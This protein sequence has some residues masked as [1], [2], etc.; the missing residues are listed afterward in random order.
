M[1]PLIIAA[2][3]G[4]VG[5]LAVSKIL[6]KDKNFYTTKE[7]AELLKI[8]EYTVRKKIREGEIQAE[9]GKSYR[10]S[11][12]ALEEYLENNLPTELLDL[13]NAESLNPEILQQII[14]LKE[15]DLKRLKL[16]LQKLELEVDDYDPKEFQKR[17]LALEIDINELEAEIKRQRLISTINASIAQKKSEN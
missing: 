1:I 17:K 5:T 16:Q 14:E 3:A 13:D 9:P 10:I 4:A 6:S 12:D 11:K 15:T 2:A 8:S 7:V